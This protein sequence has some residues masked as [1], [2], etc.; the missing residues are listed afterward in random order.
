VSP[1]GK[2]QDEVAISSCLDHPNITKVK[3]LVFDRRDPWPLPGDDG[4]DGGGASSSGAAGGGGGSS[5]SDSGN[6]EAGGKGGGGGNGGGGGAAAQGP[7]E[8]E[9]AKGMV[10]EIVQGKPLAAK[11]TSEHLLRCR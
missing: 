8:H 4:G 3:A 2:A 6:G 1:D 11:P 7:H 5:G 10:M 9:A